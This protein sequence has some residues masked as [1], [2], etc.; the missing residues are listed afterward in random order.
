MS[1]VIENLKKYIV[2]RKRQLKNERTAL[3]HFYLLLPHVSPL[4]GGIPKVH[5]SIQGHCL[6]R[7]LFLK[8]CACLF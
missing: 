6:S 8:V 3:W 5:V 1:T 2:K 7:T 4:V